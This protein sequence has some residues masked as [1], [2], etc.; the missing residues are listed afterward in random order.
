MLKNLLKVPFFKAFYLDSLKISLIILYRP[1]HK[2]TSNPT[3]DPVLSLQPALGATH[4]PNQYPT[5]ISNKS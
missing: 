4:F 3:T 2:N 5:P 1:R